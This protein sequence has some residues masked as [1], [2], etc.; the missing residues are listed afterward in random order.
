MSNIGLLYQH[1]NLTDY[2]AIY[3]ANVRIK[4]LER[5][6]LFVSLNSYL[7]LEVPLLNSRI[8]KSYNYHMSN[9]NF[10]AAGIGLNYLTYPVKLISNNKLTSLI[11]FKGKSIFSKIFAVSKNK[12][13]IFYNSLNYFF[14][15]HFF[16][17]NFEPITVNVHSSISSLTAKHVGLNLN[18]SSFNSQIYAVG[19]DINSLCSPLIYQ[20][21]HGVSAIVD[22]L[23]LLPTSIF[24]EKTSHYLNTEGFLQ[25]AH[26]AITSDKLVKKD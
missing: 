4:E 20:G 11:L 1:S 18:L 6:A 23:L 24:A 19:A 15:P 2:S 3:F 7:R 10:V 16:S 9:F 14:L 22:S 26:A 25:K 8:R 12:I 5:Y 17:K 13:I 21:S